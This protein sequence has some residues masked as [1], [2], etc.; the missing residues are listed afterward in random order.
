M[1]PV[2]RLKMGYWLFLPP[3]VAM[4]ASHCHSVRASFAGKR[5]SVQM[6]R[7]FAAIALVFDR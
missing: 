7:R 2:V 1:R 4:T 3:L 5:L 6:V